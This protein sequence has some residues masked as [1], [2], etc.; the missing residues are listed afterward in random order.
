MPRQAVIRK[1]NPYDLHGVRHYQLFISYAD[2]PD[3]V[4]EVRVAH[5]VIYPSPEEGDEVNVESLLSV[6]T[7]V[8]KVKNA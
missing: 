6:V 8:T 7:A 5:D 1:V 4:N 3:R 2:T